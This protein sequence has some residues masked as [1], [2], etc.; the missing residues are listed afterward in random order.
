[1]HQRV[2]DPARNQTR[3]DEDGRTPGTG[4]NHCGDNANSGQKPC[5]Y[6]QGW[7]VLPAHTDSVKYLGM[8]DADAVRGYNQP[9]YD[10]FG[11][12]HDPKSQEYK[13]HSDVEV[14]VH[15]DNTG[16][17]SQ[18]L[19]ALYNA[20]KHTGHAPGANFIAWLKQLAGEATGYL[21]WITCPNEDCVANPLP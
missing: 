14:V 6:I 19:Y 5:E 16:S 20:D 18:K 12:P 21:G 7:F 11:N 9:I 15:D 1:M 13:F 17:G 3:M 4:S 8:G 2:A 10:H